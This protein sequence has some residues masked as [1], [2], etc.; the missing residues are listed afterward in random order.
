MRIN[1]NHNGTS[2]KPVA[3]NK[4]VAK[5]N[6]S[7][8]K[9]K[10][11]NNPH[12][13]KTITKTTTKAHCPAA[14][15]NVSGFKKLSGEEGRSEVRW[16]IVSII[17]IEQTIGV[18]PFAIPTQPVTVFISDPFEKNPLEE[19][20]FDVVIRTSSAKSAREDIAGAV[21]NIC[22]QVTNTTPIILVA[23]ERSGTLLPGIGS[24]LRAS[25]RKLAGYVFIDGTLPVPNQ[26]ATPNSQWLEHYFDSVP[27]TEDWPNAPVVYI[28][29]R[30][31]SAIWVEQVKVRG[32]KLLV[33]EIDS[34]L[35]K[36]VKLIAG[37]TDKN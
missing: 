9:K 7:P 6:E 35:P 31:D 30:E 20:L 26:V 11:T 18:D 33:E 3:M 34:A 25:F 19:S 36:A 1:A 16:V 2:I 10:P 28:Q 22:M 13:A 32:W 14:V 27:L 21:F 17:A 12:S 5:S 8:G 4:P 15:N 23:Q 37:E 29:T 24:G